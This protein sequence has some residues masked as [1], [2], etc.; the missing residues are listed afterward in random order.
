[1]SY[2]TSAQDAQDQTV[3]PVTRYPTRIS[4]VCGQCAHSATISIFLDQT[5]R[6]RCKRCNSR[7]ALVIERDASRSKTIGWLRQRSGK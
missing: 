4:I 2:K 1:M 5:S 7:D 6:L 3:I